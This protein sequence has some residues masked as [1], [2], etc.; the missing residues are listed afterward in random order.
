MPVK[1]KDQSGLFVCAEPSPVVVSALD[2]TFNLSTQLS[3]ANK[4]DLGA[5]LGTTLAE[6]V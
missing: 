2:S 4:R 3:V 5:A 1:M 6:T